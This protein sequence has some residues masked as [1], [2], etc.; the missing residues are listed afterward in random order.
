MKR[1]P[2]LSRVP[3]DA[4]R[5]ELERRRARRPPPPPGLPRP[6]F[7]PLRRMIVECVTEAH[8]EGLWSKDWKRYVFEIAVAAVYGQAFWPWYNSVSWD[9]E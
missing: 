8:R 9:G 6:D 4:L 1:E 3:D 2:D 7:E 5:A